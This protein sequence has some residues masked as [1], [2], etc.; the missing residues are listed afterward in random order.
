MATSPPRYQQTRFQQRVAQVGSLLEGWAT[1]PWRRLSLLIIV[2]LS[3][4]A[5]G[6]GLAA[7]T[8]ALSYIDQLSALICVVAMELAVRSRRRLLQRQGDRLGLQLLD[9]AR[10]GLLY[11]LVLDGFK[12]L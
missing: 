4:F 12:L 8:G 2:L 6:G 1:N 7:I 10:I 3:A 9:M 5:V 11:G